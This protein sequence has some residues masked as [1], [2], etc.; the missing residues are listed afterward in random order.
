[1]HRAL[2]AALIFS[3]IYGFTIILQQ[4]I[5]RSSMDPVFLVTLS[6]IFTFI[7][8]LI[9]AYIAKPKILPFPHSGFKWGIA[10]A[11]LSSVL[12]DYFVIRGLQ[13]SPSIN[14][15]ILS[16][17]TVPGTFLLA[18]PILH[19]KL[20]WNKYLAGIIALFGAYFVV[21]DPS[22]VFSPKQ[23]DIFFILAVLTYSLANVTSQFALRTFSTVQLTALRLGL[24]MP[25]FLLILAFS[26]VS[27]SLN[28]PFTLFNAAMILFGT[29]TVTYIIGRAGA[30]FF[31]VTGNLIPVFTVLFSI[32]YLRV[33]PTFL[34][35]LGGA[36]VILSIFLFTYTPINR[37][38]VG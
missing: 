5:V 29:A 30:S 20:S 6:Y 16:R 10:T 9:Y 27:F 11:L 21:L 22:F 1:M 18:L 33:L 25:S 35:L 2:I 14:W 37:A 3:F 28:L 4:T 13:T 36:L 7:Y 34:Q 32:F 8:F 31:A 19:E 26:P 23:G 15:S 38:E 24:A 12:G 17:L